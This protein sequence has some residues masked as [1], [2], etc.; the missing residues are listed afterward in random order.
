MTKIKIVICA[1]MCIVTFICSAQERTISLDECIALSHSG[2]PNVVNAQLDNKAAVARRKEVLSNWFPTLSASAYGFHAMD[3]LVNLGLKD[4]LGS[5][6]AANNFRYYVETSAGLSGMKDNL[7]LLEN[8]YVASLNIA[9]PVFAGGRIAN[10]NELAVLG[11]KVAEVRNKIALRDNDDAVVQKYWTVVALSEKKKALRA[12]MNLLKSLEKDVESAVKS[13]LA[14]ER[15]L[16]QVRLKKKELETDMIRLRGG[17]KLA[18]MDLFNLVGLEYSVLSLDEI[19]LADNFSALSSP[20]NYYKDEVSA[21]ASMDETRLLEMSV[22]AKR[23]EKKMALG[24]GLPQIGVGASLGYGKIVGD[25]HPNALVYAMV[26]IPLSDWGK[27]SRKMQRLQY[28]VDKAENDKA[29]LE[30]QLLLKVNKEWIELQSTWEQVLAAKEALELAEMLEKQKKSEFDAGL[31]TLS[32]LLG[33]Q[34]E[35]QASRS[36]LVDRQTEY[37]N[38]LNVWNNY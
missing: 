30:K 1:Y 7:E 17:E 19:S 35:L 10:G 16:L 29:Y 13:G 15:D 9:Q 14:L 34:T 25:P 27:T 36:A 24:E 11:V 21:A 23:L 31:C 12:G 18:K 33:N 22:K 37:I 20:D 28:E 8:G 32:E 6:D 26:K 4:I 2:N 3:P 38:A 5:S